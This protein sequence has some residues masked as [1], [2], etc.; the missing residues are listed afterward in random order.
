MRALPLAGFAL[1]AATLS[2]CC[3]DCGGNDGYE[4][5]DLAFSLDSLTGRGYR[6]AELRTAYVVRY[7]DVQAHQVLDTLRQ[8]TAITLYWPQA[9]LGL[10]YVAAPASALAP[11]RSF[12]VVVPAAARTY[13]LTNLE[14]TVSQDNCGCINARLRSLYLDGELRETTATTKVLLEK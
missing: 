13:D 2:G 10:L 6:R 14:V 7:T 1:L 11:A 9:Q 5:L 4:Y 8:P 3:W 12:R